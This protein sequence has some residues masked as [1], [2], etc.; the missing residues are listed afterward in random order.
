M[1]DPETRKAVFRLS[2]MGMGIRKIARSL[3]ISRNAVRRIIKTK[4]AMPESARDD[5]IEIDS[6]DLRKLYKECDGY[7]RRMH[8]KLTEEGIGE[9]KK[10][11][12][13][14]YPTLTR[15]LRELGIGNSRDQ[16]CDRVPDEPGAEMQH[17]TSPFVMRLGGK[18]TKLAASVLYLR[19]SKR[20]YLKFYRS[21]RRFH[22]K[23]FLDEALSFWGYSSPLCIIDNTN[24]AR[25]RGTG[26]NAV[27]VP[28]MKAFAKKYGF[29]FECH[30][31]KHPNRKAGNERS[32]Y[33]VETNFLPGRR[34]E[35]L[36]DLNEQ[37]F[38]WATVRLE[39]KTVGKSTLIPAKAFEHEKSYLK[40]LV[41]GIAAPYLPLGRDIDQY[42]YVAVDAN[43]YWVRGE[44]RGTV[45]ALLFS[46]HL[47]IYRKRE[48]VGEYRLPPDGVKNACFSPEG[49]PKPRYKPKNRK[50]PTEEEE[51][52]LR[53]MGE[54]LESYLDFALKEK[55]PQKRHRFLREL[56]RLSCQ[57]TSVCFLRAVERAMK[58][59][60]TCV[61]TIR[62]I[63][64]RQ[65]AE[66]AA[67]IPWVEVD[68]SF[69]EREA[70]LEGRLSDEPDFSPYDDLLEEDEDHG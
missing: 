22:M 37:A 58:Y 53:A 57:M 43:F 33:T 67:T 30:A 7:R 28:E 68:E 59:R 6:D 36:E 39:N 8:E 66:G 69:A 50:R 26:K 16:R 49:L 15:M 12:D 41:P 38:Q 32:F 61:E 35:S 25:L 29:E 56:F 18:P 24:L 21:F 48:L 27:I 23:Y 70:Y 62:R 5:K 4:G 44:G 47:K 3:E 31:I 40:K 51:E 63:A 19:Y 42:G 60:I 17:D 52:R 54:V 1:I 14:A 2:E 20:R 9:E 65:L 45:T 34:F 55:G 46:E 64:L 11:Y 10:K 13:I